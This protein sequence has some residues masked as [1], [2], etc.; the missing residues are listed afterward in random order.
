V[1]VVVVGGW[2]GGRTYE[3]IDYSLHV[4]LAISAVYSTLSTVARRDFWA[5]GPW[6][7]SK[8]ER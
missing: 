7:L 3:R 5:G 4:A 6:A 2:D 1:D 8:E